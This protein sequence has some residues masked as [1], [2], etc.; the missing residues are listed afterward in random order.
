MKLY[1]IAPFVRQAIVSKMTEGKYISHRL[2]TRDHRLFFVLG[3]TGSVIIEGVAHAI[4]PG[5]LI[6]LRSGTEYRWQVN[7]M[8]YLAI[9]FD[10]T[11]ENSHLRSSFHVDRA[12]RVGQLLE[13]MI[14]F[15]DTEIMSRPTVLLG[16]HGMESE[17]MNIVKS[18]SLKSRFRDE[19]LSSL[20]KS[21]IISVARAAERDE[22]ESGEDSVSGIISYIQE[23]YNKPIKNTDIADAFHFNPSY[24]NRLFKSRTGITVR[25]FLI[26]YRLSAAIDLILGSEL[27]VGEIATAVGFSD[28]PHFIKTFKHH[29]G[30]TPTEYRAC[31]AE[32]P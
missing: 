18:F 29:V 12:E 32:Q 3:G 6:L 26:D 21:L 2:K 28:I 4:Q 25:A 7:N 16:V 23:N 31:G 20:M 30:K 13:P 11:N 27:S 19:Y 14:S 1:E 9:N 8:R 5:M 22:A 15:E 10:C 24:M 17:V